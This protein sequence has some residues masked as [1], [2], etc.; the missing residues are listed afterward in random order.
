M[1]CPDSQKNDPTAVIQGSSVVYPPGLPGT[2]PNINNT[3]FY[4]FDSYDTG[5]QIDINGKATGATE[6]HYSTDWTGPPIAGDPRNQLKY[7]DPPPDSTV[8]TWC[9][10]HIAVAHGDQIP[11]LMLN[12][13]VK[14]VPIKQFV[15]QSASLPYG[16]LNSKQ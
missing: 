1:H 16:P 6:V 3:Y 9:T 13:H 10:Y 11:V 5:P 7:P 2:Q 15:F 4:P 12:G 8:V 14:S